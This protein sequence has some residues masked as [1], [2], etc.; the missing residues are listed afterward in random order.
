MDFVYDRTQSDVDNRTAKG[1]INYTDLNR[2]EGNTKVI[3]NKLALPF[4]E[5]N[6]TRTG[7]P[8]VTADFLRIK[9]GVQAIRSGFA[10]YPDTPQ[11]PAQPLNTYQKWNDIERIL[12]DVN[13]IYDRNENAKYYC[14]EIFAGE[15]IGTL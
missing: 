12:H 13:E 7:L 1:F 10:V 9:N 6:W 5:K 15:G 14:G 2:I 8:R 4:T 11:T 3:S